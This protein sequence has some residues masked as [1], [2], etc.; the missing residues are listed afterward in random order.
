MKKLHLILAA[1]SAFALASAGNTGSSSR[2]VESPADT[3]MARVFAYAQNNGGHIGHYENTVYTKFHISS[4]T[5]NF[6]LKL[7]PHSIDPPK[8]RRRFFGENMTRYSYIGLGILDRKEVA[9]YSTMSKLRK[10]PDILHTNLNAMIYEPTIYPGRLLSPFNRRN[11]RHY[12]YEIDSV[13]RESGGGGTALLSF[14]PKYGNA[15]LVKGKARVDCATGKVEKVVFDA[16]YDRILKMNAGFDMGEGGGTASLLPRKARLKMG[17]RWGGNSVDVD[18]DSRISCENVT[19]ARH[20]DS[21][22]HLAA[23]DGRGIAAMSQLRGDTASVVRS[24]EY[25]DTRRPQPLSPEEDSLYAAAQRERAA[26]G[27]RSEAP[28][29]EDILLSRH[30][31]SF[32]DNATLALPAVF[33]PSM[34]QWS[35]SRGVSV[36]TR[37]RFNLN[38]PDGRY[39][40][41]SPRVGY[42]FKQKQLYWNVPLDIL[43]L[44]SKGMGVQAAVRNGN[45]IY[46]SVQAREVREELEKY[47]D[48]DSLLNVFDRYDFNY[49]ND[50]Y[51]DAALYVEPAAG[52]KLRAGLAY[53][54]RRLKNWNSVAS[55]NGM[56]KR[57]K[58]VAPHID[59]EFTPGLRY[60]SVSGRRI[61]VRAS[62]PTFRASAEKGMQ[63][64]G[65]NS[66]YERWEFDAT[67]KI[68][69]P[70]LSSVYLRCGGG[71][72]TDRKETYFVDYEN[73]SFHNMPTGWDDDMLGEFQLLDRNWYNESN[74]YT[75]LCTAYESPALLMSRAPGISKLV[76]QERVYLNA[77][78]LHALKIYIECGYGISTSFFDGA[79]FMGAGNASQIELGA[80][81]S[82]RFFDNW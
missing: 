78:S 29:L 63:W 4:H 46:S 34:F 7:L 22:R 38:M 25:F 33:T 17:Y 68:T 75:L 76:K 15:Q 39:A 36:Q 73:F 57:Y 37:L 61:P 69:L 27:R 23:S 31:V 82:L 71:L 41:L 40:A 74:Y 52:L 35:G 13:S 19:S 10:I 24:K 81:I 58:S 12:K 21:L 20:A 64:R 70:A 62:W 79:L 72:F 44:P 48:Y 77:V 32:N 67:Y 18:M 59:L 9:F 3:L 5:R 6:L 50:F 51:T 65:C 66:R 60:A 43:L 28:T 49:Y 16:V 53:H 11:S 80:K 45:R 42:S 26:A 1:T 14:T 55:D 47:S 2:R 8:G 56:K 54:D 30:S